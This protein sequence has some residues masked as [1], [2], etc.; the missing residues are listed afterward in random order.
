MERYDRLLVGNIAELPEDEIRSTSDIIDTLEAAIWSLITTRN[1]ETA[2]IRAV[3][4]GSD[5][6]AIG[7]LAGAIAGVYYGEHAIPT[8]WL[9]QVKK[10][11]EIKEIAI[12]FAKTDVIFAL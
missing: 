3:N 11:K 1:Y 5:S 10:I 8:R 7:A 4:L 6:A 12:S 2:V 9:D